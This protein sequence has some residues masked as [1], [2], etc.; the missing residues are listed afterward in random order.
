MLA[1][2]K[3]K[4]AAI[5]PRM[6]RFE[7]LSA[8]SFTKSKLKGGWFNEKIA[9]SYIWGLKMRA[10]ANKYGVGQLAQIGLILTL[11]TF[12]YKKSKFK[13]GIFYEKIVIS[14]N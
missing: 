5:Q 12:S 1:V 4:R 3:N 9:N 8:L 6:D 14:C 7:K 11:I 2:L 13:G 10:V